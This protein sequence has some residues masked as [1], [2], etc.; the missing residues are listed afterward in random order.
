MRQ[1]FKF[2]LPPCLNEQINVARSH[3]SK[4]A[5]L[6]KQ[7]GNIIM[8][9]C[10]NKPAFPDKV[11]LSFH[12]SVAFRHDPDN[13]AASAKYIMDGMVKSGIIKNDNL[14]IIQSPVMH[15]YSKP[16]KKEPESVVV[17]ISSDSS[18]IIEEI[19]NHGFRLVDPIVASNSR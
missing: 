3:W 1:Y 9:E 11:W 17:A 10:F 15:W 13:V 19:T 8:I 18:L 14:T 6:K 12:W 5:A 4:S 7:W 16:T 2:D